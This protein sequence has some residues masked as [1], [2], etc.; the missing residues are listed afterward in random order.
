MSATPEVEASVAP[1]PDQ[2]IGL[3]AKEIRARYGDAAVEAL[4]ARMRADAARYH[5]LSRLS[6][7]LELLLDLNP[8][9]NDTPALRLISDAMERAITTPRSRLMISMPPQEGKSRLSRHAVVRALQHDPNCRI[10][11][12]SY[13]ERLARKTGEAARNIVRLF[14]SNAADPVTGTPMADRLGI[15]VAEGAATASDWM[16][17]IPGGRAEG[18]IL[19]VGVGSG[20]TGNPVDLLIVDDPIKGRQEADSEVMRE[21]L[22]DWWDNDA[23]SRLAV[24]SSA[25]IIQT[26]WHEDDLIGWLLGDSADPDAEEFGAERDDV[27]EV[28]NIP[29]LADGE[30]LDS[31]SGVPGGRDADGWLISARG[32][33]VPKWSRLRDRRPRVWASLYQGRPAPLEGGIFQRAWFEDHR[34]TDPEQ[35][36]TLREVVLGV[37]PADTGTGDAAGILVAGVGLDQHL[38][39]LAD[40]SG[41]LSQAAWARRVCMAWV[42]YDAQ[43]VIQEHNLGMRTS[44]PDA[45]SVLRRQAVALDGFGSVEAA[46]EMLADRGDHAAADQAG[47]RQIEPLAAKIVAIGANGPRVSSVPVRISKLQRAE[48]ATQ[49][50]Q[51]GRAHIVGRL[52]ALEHECC[53]WQPG[54]DSPNRVD[55]LSMLVQQLART[56]GRGRVLV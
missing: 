3:T 10:A 31:L 49:P 8:T 23:D 42:R 6:G 46:S 50:F 30:T 2:I 17:A 13:Q 27:W 16:V 20:I 7:P 5:S 18:G 43:R 39:F 1:E 25:I 52:P 32:D 36:P 15:G 26:R 51:D 45:W 33:R 11:V 56:S 40:L 29:A 24:D 34:I 48:S 37:D 9:W 4:T 55:T 38:Y 12:A 44:V 54:Q 47:L 28:I 22:H 53:M 21:A 35:I 19:S 41:M 14:G